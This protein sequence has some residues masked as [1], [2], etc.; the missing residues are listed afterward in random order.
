MRNFKFKVHTSSSRSP[1]SLKTNSTMGFFQFRKK[2]SKSGGLISGE[3]GGCGNTS[4]WYD[5]I[6]DVTLCDLWHVALS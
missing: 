4:Q 2:R 3:N 5:A 6:S 1:R